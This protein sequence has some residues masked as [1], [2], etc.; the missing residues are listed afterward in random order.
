MLSNLTTTHPL[1]FK[2]AVFVVVNRSGFG[3]GSNS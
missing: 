2:L 1:L 3:G